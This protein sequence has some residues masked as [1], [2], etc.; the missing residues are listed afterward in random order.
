MTASMLIRCEITLKQAENR[1]SA[2]I[3]VCIYTFVLVLICCVLIRI[4]F[5]DILRILNAI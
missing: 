2:Y 3:A 1:I 4:G 5:M